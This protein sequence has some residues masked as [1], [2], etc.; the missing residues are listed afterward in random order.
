MTTIT[1]AKPVVLKAASKLSICKGIFAQSAGTAR[2]DIIAKF[3]SE[4][5]CSTA[6]AA[7]YYAIC[8]KEAET[9]AAAVEAVTT[10]TNVTETATTETKA[11]ET[12]LVAESEVAVA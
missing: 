5:G 7:T 6:G 11:E 1:A 8:K 2:K 9:K 10:E 12:A 3:I 4:A